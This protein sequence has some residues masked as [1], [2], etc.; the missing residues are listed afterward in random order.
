MLHFKDQSITRK[1]MYVAMWVSMVA[2]LVASSI[3][4]LADFLFSRRA[5]VENLYTFANVI[6]SNSV[7]ALTFQDRA[8][9]EEILLALREGI[10]PGGGQHDLPQLQPKVPHS[11]GQRGQGWV[12]PLTA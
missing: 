5:M 4:V 6:G 12:Q 10:L 8:N 3:N 9:A 11:F 2:L 1:L 7:A